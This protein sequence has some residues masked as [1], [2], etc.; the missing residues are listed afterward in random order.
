MQNWIFFKCSCSCSRWQPICPLPYLRSTLC[1]R[2]PRARLP[3]I[4]T[5]LEQYP[6][7]TVSNNKQNARCNPPLIPS[8]PPLHRAPVFISV[9]HWTGKVI[10]KFSGCPDVPVCFVW[11]TASCRWLRMSVGRRTHNQ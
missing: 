9:C 6:S 10:Q 11:V 3:I 5:L 8:S 1:C 4:C 2:C 7:L